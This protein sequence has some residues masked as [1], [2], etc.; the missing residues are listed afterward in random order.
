MVC[1]VLF[2][3]QLHCE[4]FLCPFTGRNAGALC[5]HIAPGTN[6]GQFHFAT[7]FKGELKVAAVLSLDSSDDNKLRD[8]LSGSEVCDK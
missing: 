5:S 7:D 1:L 3:T 8:L 6:S 4:Y 2:R